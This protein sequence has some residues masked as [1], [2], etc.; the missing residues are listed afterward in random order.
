MQDTVCKVWF[1]PALLDTSELRKNRASSNGLAARLLKAISK[2]LVIFRCVG[3][4][5]REKSIVRK[6]KAA[7]NAHRWRPR[8]FTRK[9]VLTYISFNCTNSE[10][11]EEDMLVKTPSILFIW[12]FHLQSSLQNSVGRV[13][14]RAK[15]SAKG[16]CKNQNGIYERE[17]SKAMCRAAIFQIWLKVC[18][19]TAMSSL[20]EKIIGDINDRTDMWIWKLNSW[21]KSQKSKLRPIWKSSLIRVRTKPYWTE[22]NYPVLTFQ[23]SSW[24]RNWEGLL[25]YERYIPL[26]WPSV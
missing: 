10:G 18:V 24:R 25:N 9:D 19:Q 26:K 5:E 4:T 6:K 8:K 23:E 21:T 1:N 20:V 15:K 12:G 17:V 22:K 16:P 14:W 2:V 11:V 7:K 13:I 3:K